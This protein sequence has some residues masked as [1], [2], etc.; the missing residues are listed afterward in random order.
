M[1]NIPV[2]NLI[3]LLQEGVRTVG[4]E[5]TEEPGNQGRKVYTYRS[6]IEDLEPGDKVVVFANPNYKVATVVHVDEGDEIDL[7]DKRGYKWV[8]DKVDI[9]SYAAQL[10]ADKA[11]I[12]KMQGMKRES[13]KSTILG[14]LGFGDEAVNQL[15]QVANTPVEP[16]KDEAKADNSELDL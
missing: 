5:F 12:E 15:K 9:Y 3:C 16:E 1:N 8:V 2:K 14:A 10:R 4:V 6:K 13:A 7:D 11:A